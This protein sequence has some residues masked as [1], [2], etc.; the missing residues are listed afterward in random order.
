MNFRLDISSEEEVQKVVWALHSNK[1]LGPNGISINLYRKC[2][3]FIKKYPII[4]LNW[5][6]YKENIGGTK[7]SSF[8]DLIPK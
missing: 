6:K 2:R 7:N 5:S 1:S 8:I 3:P 4:M